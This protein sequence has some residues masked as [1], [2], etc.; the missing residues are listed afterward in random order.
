ID[1]VGGL[2]L[3]TA[4]HGNADDMYEHHK[5]GSVQ[6]ENGRPKVKTAH[7]LN[8]VPCIIYDPR[9]QNDYQLKLREGLGISSVAASCLN[10]LGYEA[11]EDYDQSL[12]IPNL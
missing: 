12:I 3:I 10:L 4:D 1:Q 11:P 9:F 2:M 5:D 8:P 6:M 7:S